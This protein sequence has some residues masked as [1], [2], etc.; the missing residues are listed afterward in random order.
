LPGLFLFQD[1]SELTRERKTIPLG[2]IPIAEWFFP[3]KDIPSK[4]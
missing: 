2:K 3:V 1:L 4:I